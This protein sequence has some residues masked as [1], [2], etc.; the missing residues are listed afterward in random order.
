MLTDTSN[1]ELRTLLSRIAKGDEPAFRTLF[2][3]YKVRFYAVSLKM[4]RSE[5]AAEEIVQEVFLSL[6]RNRQSLDSIESPDSYLFTA[7][8]RRVYNFYKKQAIERKLLEAVSLSPTVSA[9]TEETLLA[10]ERAR[11]INEAINQ[12]PPQQQLV[13]RLSKQEGL[14]RNEIAEKLN[15]SPNTVK[16]HLAEALKFL[17]IKLQ[18]TSLAFPVLFLMLD[19]KN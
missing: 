19:G 5:E 1:I 4:T 9:L 11:L 7:V 8:Y 3:H 16:N 2:E 10:K 12:L 15:I 6:W 13:L 14:S 18:D 17:K